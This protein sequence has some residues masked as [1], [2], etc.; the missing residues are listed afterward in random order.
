MRN[1]TETEDDIPAVL[2][3]R[4]RS[5]GPLDPGSEAWWRAVAA[6]VI[7]GRWLAVVDE[8]DTVLGAGRA[9]PFE[10]AWGGRHLAMGG[11]AGVYV[12]P[13]ARGR[14]AASVLMRGLLERM[15]GLGDA[16][17][18]LF[19]TA[20]ALYRGVGYEF[21]GVRPRYTYAAHDLRALRALGGRLRPRP[22]VVA[23]AELVHSVM[24]ADQV[25]HRLCGPRLPSVPQWREQLADEQAIHY[26]LDGQDG[27]PKGFVA[28]SLADSTL[29]VTDLVGDSAPAAAA[30]WGVVASG[31]STAP[32]V[33][34][35]LDPRDPVA[36]L[37]GAEARHEVRQ[38]TWMLR[39]VDLVKAVAGRGFAP[40]LTASVQVRLHDPD[41]P[42]NSG[43]WRLDVSDGSGTATR[44]ESDVAEGPAADAPAADEPV[45]DEPVAA[46][47]S[48]GRGAAEWSAGRGATEWSA[49]RGAVEMG[50]RGLAALWCGWSMSRLRQAGL[51]AGGGL[52]DDA[53]LDAIFACTPFMTE[54]F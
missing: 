5:F 1:S 27:G 14:G 40:H 3:I 34:A 48:A 53:C 2:T 35:Y 4:R 29:T 19:A 24:R 7:S 54:Y 25:R 52:D 22:A 23:D 44:I 9:R 43:T 41:L 21:G 6:E 15:A 37:A 26:V 49:A 13:A 28:Y 18:C 42:A 8:S 31:S 10:Q 51:A 20:P 36:L 30:L 16:V 45:A 12:D 46:E 17:T 47:W 11:V 38:Q 50:P 39:V 32:T 33:R